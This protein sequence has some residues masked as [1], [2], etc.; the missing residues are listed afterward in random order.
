MGDFNKDN[1]PDIF[2]ADTGWDYPPWPGASPLLILS[3][4]NGLQQSGDFSSIVGY[5]HGAASADIDR[6]GDLDIFVTST[7][8]P[9]FLINDGT[10]NFTYTTGNLPEELFGEE[11]LFKQLYTTE[12]ID[13]DLD[14]YYDLLVAGHEW[15]YGQLD[16][17]IYWGNQSGVFSAQNKTK[18]PGV[19][20]WGTVVDIDAEDIDNDGDVD[21]VLNRTG[22]NSINPD[23]FYVGCYIQIIINNGSRQFVDDTS[24]RITDGRID[25]E[26]VDWIRFQDRMKWID[27]IRLQDINGDQAVDIIVDDAVLSMVW[28]NNGEGQFSLT[29]NINFNKKVN[30]PFLP[31]LLLN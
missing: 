11:T 3:S 28:L 14:G 4:P 6:D 22:D 8:Q 9:F 30:L 17:L 25:P 12:L 19:A 16:S 24:S 2:V 20:E 23:S 7:V 13:I 5:H 15:G 1:L 27:W 18:L 10:G 29:D 26:W 31:M 21:I